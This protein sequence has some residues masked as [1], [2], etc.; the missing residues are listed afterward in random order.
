MLPTN[1]WP[2]RRK[3]GVDRRRERRRHGEVH[4]TFSGCTA[5]PCRVCHCFVVLSAFFWHI[6]NIL[7]TPL[8]CTINIQL[9]IL[10]HSEAI[11]MK[12]LSGKI[13][14]G[15]KVYK[16]LYYILY[17]I[18]T[19]IGVCLPVM[20]T[21]GFWARNQGTSLCVA[22]RND[23]SCGE[24]SVDHGAKWCRGAWGQ[25]SGQLELTILIGGE[26]TTLHNP[27]ARRK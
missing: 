8:Y 21:R 7:I 4:L 16:R 12:G 14:L 27:G 13:L 11:K 23:K 17:F 6:N 24:E 9:C 2:C 3:G 26:F 5:Y 10:M 18:G 25:S 15:M 1:T 20:A 22:V 19:V